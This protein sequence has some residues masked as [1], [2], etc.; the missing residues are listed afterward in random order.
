[1]AYTFDG[2]NKLIIL[3][4]GTTT[5]DSKDMYSRWKDWVMVG[6]NAKY[7]PA[8]SVLGGDPLPGSRFLGTTYFLENG[9]KI[10]PYEGNHT[11]VLSGNL[12]SKDG[13]DPFVNT[14]GSYNV[15]V[16]LS[17]S[18]LVDTINTG[19]GVGTVSEVA[20]AVWNAVASSHNT[21]GTTGNKLNSAGSSGDPWSADLSLYD[22]GTAGKTL[23]DIPGS[24]TT[25][26]NAVNNVSV[27]S[28]AIN[29]GAAGFTLTSGT[30][31]SGTYLDTRTYDVAEHY[32]R[33]NA[34]AFDIEYQFDIGLSAIP[35]SLTFIG[36]VL[37]KH[38]TLDVSAWNYNT[39]TWET[40][41]QV[42]GTNTNKSFTG[43]LYSDHVGF[44]PGQIG[45]VRI[46]MHSTVL[47][48]IFVHIDQLYVSYAK[49]ERVTGYS[50][51]VAS[52]SSTT[53]TL[54]TDAVTTD[55]YYT[56]A[57]IMVNHGTGAFQYA[58]AISYTGS[59][60]TLYLESAMPITLDATSHITLAPWATAD[61]SASS[62]TAITNSVWSKVTSSGKT[63][64]QWLEGLLSLNKF[65][66]LK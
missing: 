49:V 42:S 62:Q 52:A 40:V 45:D 30:V 15:R 25:I 19:G 43:A 58:K 46:R 23:A 57:L 28:A 2:P 55:N 8:F 56:P 6:T 32:I 27:S 65:L 37:D 36:Y 10:R 48:D 16:M 7:L 3:T 14:L 29:A 39:L 44:L 12:Y 34:G 66:G 21:A 4:T 50:G 63:T 53:L 41:T 1:M 18:N 54:G 38:E 59:T 35:A 5:V 47:S 31:M 61:V 60:R 20:D 22:P 64:I 26:L 33:D 9:W 24:Q 13:S 11:L 17:T 51:H